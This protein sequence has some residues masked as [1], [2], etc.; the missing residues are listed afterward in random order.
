LFAKRLQVDGYVG[1]HSLVERNAV[2][3]AFS[4]RIYAAGSASSPPPALTPIASEARYPLSD[5][6]RAQPLG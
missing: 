6:S 4:G 1:C 3:F 5:R 2:V